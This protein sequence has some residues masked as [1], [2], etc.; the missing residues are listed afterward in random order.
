MRKLDWFLFRGPS[1]IRSASLVALVIAVPTLMAMEE[2]PDGGCALALDKLESDVQ[3]V[4]TV[5][6]GVDGTVNV[7]LAVVNTEDWESPYFID[8]VK[9]AQVRVPGGALVDLMPAEK[10]HYRASSQDSPDLEYVGGETY[11]IT[12][13]I[14]KTADAGDNAGAEFIAVVDA[15]DDEVTFEL[16]E[17]PEFVGDTAEI[18]WHPTYREA[19]LQINGPSGDVVFSTF[20]WSDPKFDGGKWGS[21][22][23]GGDYTLPV[24]TFDDPGEYILNLCAVDSREGF[25]EEVS[26]TLG[27]ASGF[28]AGRCAEAIVIDVPE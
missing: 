18:E 3:A 27:I 17:P 23:R 15:P 6:E 26:G 1:T 12:F 8:S 4:T 20:D 24:D 21:L 10:G 22:I 16:V 13:E 5:T 14:N 11:R 2:D 9:N 19:V 25:D 28:L 7:D